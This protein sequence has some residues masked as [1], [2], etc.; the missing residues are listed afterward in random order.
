MKYISFYILFTIFFFL[1]TI[2]QFFSS[3]PIL[4]YTRARIPTGTIKLSIWIHI[5]KG[6]FKIGAWLIQ[7]LLDPQKNMCYSF[8]IHPVRVGPSDKRWRF[9]PNRFNTKTDILPGYSFNYLFCLFVSL[10]T[11]K[12]QIL[13]FREKLINQ[14]IIQ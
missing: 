5:P 12:M 7:H 9:D 14:Y 4:V 1:T 13:I 8:Y 3:T 10:N 2:L 11:Q 6:G